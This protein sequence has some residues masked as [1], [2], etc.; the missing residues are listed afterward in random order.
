MSAHF[1][2]LNTV[3]INWATKLLEKRAD[4]TANRPRNVMMNDIMGWSQGVGLHVH[5]ERHKKMRRVIASALHPTAA[6]SYAPQ[7]L[8]NTHSFLT[9]IAHSPDKYRE[10]AANAIGT[11]II[12]MTYGVDEKPLIPFAHETMGYFALGLTG[13]FWVNDIPILKYVPSWFPGAGFKRFG[14]RGR[15]L[16]NR[17][18]QNQLRN[19]SYTSNLLETKGGA[20]ASPEDVDLVKWTAAAMFLVGS[21][22]T[23]HVIFV[24]FMM[25]ALYPD[26]AERAQAEID[27]VV[28]RGRIPDFTDRE[29]LPYVEALLQ[30]VMRISP[31]SSLG[32][33]HTATEDIEFQ[34]YRIPKNTTIHMEPG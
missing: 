28:G 19:T 29:S 6:R 33:P 15:Q 31:P 8:S 32:I 30:E 22:T 10:H 1:V 26:L 5:D 23:T 2:Y 7:H 18:H 25:M 17:Y 34:G 24:F 16:R 9:R 14:Q 13:H 21:S 12:Q 3:T 20:N 11:F 27:S 4:V